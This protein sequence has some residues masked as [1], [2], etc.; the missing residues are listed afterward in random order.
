MVPMNY[1]GCLG[2]LV[3]DEASMEREGDFRLFLNEHEK[4][5]RLYIDIR[6]PVDE[7][8]CD[9]AVLPIVQG[10]NVPGSWGWDGNRERPTL[11]P[12][13]SHSKHAGYTPE[14]DPITQ[15]VWHGHMVAGNLQAA[16]QPQP[17]PQ[18]HPR[19]RPP[20]TNAHPMLEFAQAVPPAPA[21]QNPPGPDRRDPR[22]IGGW[23][24]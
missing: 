20:Q 23:G 3:P 16:G 22:R 14:G 13:I 8:H 7:E 5:A 9:R 21:P 2:R 24:S 17:G 1:R 4:P 6:L 18:V 19:H 10:P 15:E 11:D 12:S